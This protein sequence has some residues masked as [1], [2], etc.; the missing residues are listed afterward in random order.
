MDNADKQLIK[1]TQ[2]FRMFWVLVGLDILLVAYIIYQI[3]VIF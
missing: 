3:I 1:A 2:K